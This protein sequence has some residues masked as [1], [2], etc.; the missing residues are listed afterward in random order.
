MVWRL[1]MRWCGLTLLLIG[2]FSSVMGAQN[3]DMAERTKPCIACHGDMGRAGPD[4]YY[5]RLAGKPAGYLYNQMQNFSQGRRHYTMM[6]R[7]M[8]PLA[9]EYQ[10]EMAVYFS[11]LKVPYPASVATAGVAVSAQAMQRGRV[12]A[13]QG[14]ASLKLPACA[15]CHGAQLAGRGENVPGLLGL[16]PAYLSAQLSAWRSGTRQAQSPDCMA[17][18]AKRL[19]PEDAHAVVTWLSQQNPSAPPR[20]D[21]KTAQAVSLGLTC[22]SAP[23]L[24][25]GLR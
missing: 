14:D 22:G 4:G 2:G 1:V 24:T 3:A 5:P 12:L 21:V 25:S 15:E 13:E 8:E 20:I 18:I 9:S 17:D 10:K 11:Q 23:D 7:M 19:T 16:P 6:R